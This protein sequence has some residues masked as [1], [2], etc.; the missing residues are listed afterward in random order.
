MANHINL[1]VYLQ[2][3]MGVSGLRIYAI[4]LSSSEISVTHYAICSDAPAGPI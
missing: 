2:R 3:L 1:F 4:M